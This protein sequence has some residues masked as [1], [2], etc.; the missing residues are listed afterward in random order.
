MRLQRAGE[1]YGEKAV[2]GTESQ[3][4]QRRLA[5]L[6]IEKDKAFAAVNEVCDILYHWSLFEFTLEPFLVD[7]VLAL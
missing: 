1:V 7:T 2:L 6:K 3:E 5:Q 4:L